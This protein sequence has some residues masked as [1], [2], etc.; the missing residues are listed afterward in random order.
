[1]RMRIRMG[2]WL[3]WIGARARTN[4][5]AI[6][7]GPTSVEQTNDYIYNLGAAGDS[8]TEQNGMG[9]GEETGVGSTNAI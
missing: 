8:I 2:M 4:R 5:L 6:R 9:M 3:W 7:L 1:M